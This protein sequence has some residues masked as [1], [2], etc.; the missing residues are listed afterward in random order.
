MCSVNN[1]S[2]LMPTI[3][4]APQLFAATVQYFAAAQCLLNQETLPESNVANFQSFDFIIIG[5]GTAGSVV[6]R[7]LSEVKGWKILLVEAGGDPPVESNIPG[8]DNTIADSEFNWK[9]VSTNNQV[10]DQAI[11]NGSIKLSRGKMF[12]GSTNLNEMHYIRGHDKDF[13]K[14]FKAGNGDW[15]LDDVH[16]CFKKA[17][18]LQNMKLLQDPNINQFYGKEGPIVI[19]KFNSTHRDITNG[20][21]KACHE[22][23]I[24][25][26]PDLN[27]AGLMGCGIVTATAADGVRQS[28]NT[29]YLAPIKNRW[30]LKILK[31]AF[32]RKI[33]ITSD[34][35]LAFGVEVEKDGRILNFYSTHEVI[36]SAG[37]VNSPQ[38]LMLSGIGPYEHL[39]SK[40]IPCLVN[41]PMVGQNLQDHLVVPITVYGDGPEK[42]TTKEHH[43]DIINY[44]FDRTGS[45]A[46]SSIYTDI[47]AFFSTS[48]I[49]YPEF[50][51][52]LSIIPK[53][54]T[55]LQKFLKS[56]Y[57]YKNTII[58]SMVAINKNHS[59]YFFSFTLLHP[60]STG[61][62]SLN[63]NN[64]KDAPLIFPN[65]FNDPRDLKASIQ[66]LKMASKLAK[67]TFFKNM[68]GF[69]GRMNWPA[70]NSFELDS[71]KYWECISPNI[72][73]SMSHLVGT[74]KMGPDPKTSVV[75][76]RLKVHG[77]S[78]LRVVDA[79]VMPDITSGNIY[80]PSLMIAE[81]A[82][83][84]IKEEF[85]SYY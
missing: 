68:G 10:I 33:L 44:I 66:G 54:T 55:D 36:L 11:V 82:A 22:I 14:W 26:V 23:G 71:D 40:N 42:K 84:F 75:N 70:C 28:T 43:R 56:K 49:S 31:N 37:A 5:G 76:S 61:N 8:F 51:L 9:S 62:I 39:H 38:L 27:A 45:L 50:Q 34:S 13:Q 72:V 58:D 29:G 80:A 25:Y 32:T 35:K 12:G 85:S 16:R 18:S 2:C 30:N 15:S 19:N 20:V 73:T 57:G 60:H 79:S 24:K 41:S 52:Y 63:T 17:E 67:T 64:P 78:H 47:T 7:R 1:A 77:V 59:I 46:E 3:G 53:N 48:N 21:L 6:A 74:C 83:E 65:Y 4:A 69:L 81:K